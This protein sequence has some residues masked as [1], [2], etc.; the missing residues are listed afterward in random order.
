MKEYI[1]DIFV[2]ALISG[3]YKQGDGLLRDVFDNYC[4]LGVLS[5]I[6]VK[7]GIIPKPV[8][9]DMKNSELSRYLYDG[10]AIELSDKV[11]EWAGMRTCYGDISNTHGIINMDG[12]LISMNDDG[13]SF[14]E[15]AAAIEENWQNI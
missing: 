1:K 8:F 12:S 7:E 11:K 14:V 3:E 10:K 2:T 15:I 6:A 9:Q 13:R 4:C 5:E